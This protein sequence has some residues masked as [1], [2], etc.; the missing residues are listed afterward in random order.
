MLLRLIFNSANSPWHDVRTG[1]HR[2][3]QAMKLPNCFSGKRVCTWVVCAE[4]FISVSKVCNSKRYCETHFTNAITNEIF[5]LSENAQC[6]NA[7][8]SS[9]FLIGLSSGV[10][11]DQGRCI[12]S[13]WARKQEKTVGS[14]ATVVQG[15]R[16]E[17]FKHLVR[18]I[19]KTHGPC[20]CK[21]GLKNQ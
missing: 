5:L 20:H 1:M 3:W 17:K 2:H 7:M 15:W 19:A 10:W 8:V 21:I 14:L 13:P 9:M 11:A 4:A 12:S 16:E 18:S 6:Y